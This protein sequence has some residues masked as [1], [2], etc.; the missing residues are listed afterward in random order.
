VRLLRAIS[1][2]AALIAIV[3]FAVASLGLADSRRAWSQAQAPGMVTD[4]EKA[5][6]PPLDL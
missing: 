1:P 5:S 2:A 4:D 6:P 3:A